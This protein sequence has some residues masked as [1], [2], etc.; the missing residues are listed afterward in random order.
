MQLRYNIQV[1]ELRHGL[2]SLPHREIKATISLGKRSWASSLQACVVSVSQI[3]CYLPRGKAV[4]VVHVI[5]ISL[6]LGR[7]EKLCLA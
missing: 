2:K 3:F 5:V 4:L 1:Y 6:L 7:N